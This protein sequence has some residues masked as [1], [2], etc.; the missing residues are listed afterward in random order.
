MFRRQVVLQFG[1]FAIGCEGDLAAAA[2]KRLEHLTDTAKSVDAVKVFG[3]IESLM[4]RKICLR[5]D[6]ARSGAMI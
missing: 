3:F 4:A 5:W 2:G 1:A 6:A